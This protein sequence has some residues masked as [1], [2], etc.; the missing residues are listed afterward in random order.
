[1]RTLRLFEMTFPTYPNTPMDV[2]VFSQHINPPEEHRAFFVT[3]SPA[4][5]SEWTGEVCG[6]RNDSAELVSLLPLYPVLAWPWLSLAARKAWRIFAKKKW[7][8]AKVDGEK[9]GEWFPCV[10]L[11]QVEVWMIML[12]SLSCDELCITQNT[13]YLDWRVFRNIFLQNSHLGESILRG[14]IWNCLKK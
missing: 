10:R 8:F 11:I 2:H 4:P 6:P 1:M 3:V 14:K 9:H 5:L 7:Q 13:K 12:F